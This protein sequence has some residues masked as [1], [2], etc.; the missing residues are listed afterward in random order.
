MPT[1]RRQFLAGGAA[2]VATSVL[3]AGAVLTA[4]GREPARR[5]P[6]VVLIVADDLG[7]AELGGYGQRLIRTP[8]LDRLAAG[9]MRF[10]RAYAAAPV[11]APS[12]CALLTGRHVGHGTVRH[13]ASRGRQPAL[14]DGDTTFG[15]VLRARGYRTS[16]VGKWGF[17]PERGRQ[18]SHPNERGFEDF[19]GYLTHQH[20]Q[21]HYPRHL[22][23][24][25]ER[26]AL[27]PDTY[28]ADALEAHALSRMRRP[29]AADGRPFLL[30]LAP[31]L[32]H[33]PNDLP[34]AAVSAHGDWPR[35]LP[36]RRHAAQ[37]ARLDRMAGAVLDELRRRRLDRDTL[38]LV[39]SDNG[40][41]EEDGT[42]PDSFDANGPLRGYKRNLYDGGIRVPLL[43]RWPGTIAAGGSS[44]RLT[45]LTDVLPTLA[46]LAGGP[47][48]DG[49]DG[50]SL[51]PLLTGAGRAAEHDH[52][53]WYRGPSTATPRAAATEPGRLGR[54]AEAVV[55]GKWKAVRYGAPGRRGAP[56]GAGDFELY[57]LAADPGETTNVAARH[58]RLVVELTALMRTSWTEP[59]R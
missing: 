8:R 44:G 20:A 58:P 31:N 42:D 53:Y 22:W 43:A 55:R 14:G 11:C 1:T 29:L 16:W 12:R 46:E 24:N 7:R 5:P 26:H 21:D 28:A 18:P 6:Y 36:D 10:T 50:L 13:N 25:D 40:P 34:A 59:R 54:A 38:V 57:D 35:R 17:G 47:A 19:F 32:P 41:H 39:T 49:G 4:D 52:L 48:P 23:H 9:G 2:A 37:V 30:V 27:P 15:E 56:E 33:A 3:G 45:S 51:V